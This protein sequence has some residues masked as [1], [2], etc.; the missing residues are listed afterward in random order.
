MSR[1]ISVNFFSDWKAENEAWDGLL[2]AFSLVMPGTDCDAGEGTKA[3]FCEHG[4]T[5]QCQ[6]R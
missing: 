4:E 6:P 1:E 3:I 2:R 5:T